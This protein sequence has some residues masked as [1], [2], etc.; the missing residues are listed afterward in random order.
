MTE[1]T[2]A[3]PIIAILYDFDK[4]LCTKDMQEYSF[5]PSLGM[6]REAFWGETN[7]LAREQKMD[8]ILAYMY[9]MIRKSREK[10]R[11]IGR[12]TFVELG[13]SVE[14]FPGVETW[15]PRMDAFGAAQ[16]VDVE[17]YIISSGLKEIIEGS[18]IAR[19]FKEIY[20][21]EF[22]Y[23]ENGI[24]DWPKSVVNYTT[25]TQYLFR[26]NK[27]VPDMSDDDGINRYTP[28]ERRRVPFRNMIYIGDGMTDVPCMKLVKVGGGKS[29]AVHPRG[30]GG[31]ERV[32]TLL[33]EERVDFIFPADYSEGR[34]LEE[35]VQAVVSGM[36]T[37]NRLA[38][39][40]QAQLKDAARRQ[41]AAK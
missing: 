37:A 17:H 15:F 6:S 8:R 36:A 18:V 30:R 19:N 9:L 7:K 38:A 31:K 22:H 39:R 12:D 1:K 26:I 5:I 16:G 14:Y 28:E 35:T 40:H 10:N 34:K 13:K 25:K 3:K 21:C 24:A 33:R 41:G 2:E 20:A 29:I 32:E 11:P 23:E 27:G 4:T